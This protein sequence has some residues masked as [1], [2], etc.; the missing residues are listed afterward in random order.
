MHVHPRS[1]Y[2]LKAVH[3]PELK[4]IFCPYGCLKPFTKLAS[5][6]RL[7]PRAILLKGLSTFYKRHCIM[8]NW[9]TSNR[10]LSYFSW[11]L[12]NT[13]KS[14]YATNI[15]CYVRTCTWP[16]STHQCND[17]P[18]LNI[19][20]ATG[21]VGYFWEQLA[22]SAEKKIDLKS[23]N[24]HHYQTLYATSICNRI[25]LMISKLS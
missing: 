25:M 24:K 21:P 13:V 22:C 6:L 3:S 12:D 16:I 19:S 1:I 7:N 11:W 23:A 18:L 4:F 9:S 8:A 17:S 15:Y 10:G 20:L 5:I 14:R 2:P